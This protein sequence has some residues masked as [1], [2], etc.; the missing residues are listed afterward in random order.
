MNQFTASKLAFIVITGFLAISAI[1]QEFMPY[2]NAKITE[3]QWATYFEEVKKAHEESKREFPAEHLVVYEDLKG[4]MFWAFTTPGH[5]AHPAWITRQVAADQPGQT[6]MNQIGYF[7]GQEEPFA[8]LFQDYLA[9]TERARKQKG[10][11]VQ[12]DKL[13]FKEALKMVTDSNLKSGYKEYVKEFNE[14]NNQAK[15]GARGGCYLMR[16][17]DVHLIVVI[18]DRGIIESV[19]TDLDNTKAQCFKRAYAGVAV[20]KPP[21]S[22]LAIRIANIRLKN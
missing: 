20:K 12:S 22:P 8:K 15:L 2:P 6:K 21:F 14:Y 13:S 9:L 18:T 7:A 19:A 4:G 5:P 16:D 10:I 17:E 3:S 11:E 1:A